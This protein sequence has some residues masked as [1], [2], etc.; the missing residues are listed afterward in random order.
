M[1][2]TNDGQSGS[3]TIKEFVSQLVSPQPSSISAKK[4]CHSPFLCT[5][6]MPHVETFA[7]RRSPVG[8]VG[9]SAS[10]EQ[11]A[12][13]QAGSHTHE[14]AI[15]LPFSRQSRSVEQPAAADVLRSATPKA[16]SSILAATDVA[17][18]DR[19]AIDVTNRG[20]NARDPLPACA[21]C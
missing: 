12:P 16:T 14:P 11:F 13:L 7:C 2:R 21:G 20:S 8:E 18:R 3:L 1:H 15:H 10:V 5:V 9:C 19:R 17:S 4:P 6:P